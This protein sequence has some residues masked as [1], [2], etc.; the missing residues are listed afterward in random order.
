VK[1]RLLLVVLLT[2]TLLLVTPAVA[3][4]ITFASDLFSEG[5]NFGANQCVAPVGAWATLPAG[6]CWVS[7][8]NTGQGG[9]SP[10]NT[11]IN[12]VPTAV[13]TETVVLPYGDNSGYFQGWADDTMSVYIVNALHPGG[14]LL[15]AANNVW[16][17]HCVGQPIG[18]VDGMDWVGALDN[19]ILAQG[20]NTFLMPTYQLW[21]DGF[22]VAY[23][24]EVNSVPEPLS[25]FMIGGGLLALGFCGRR[26]TTA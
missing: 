21:G 3:T 20:V 24:G 18:C 2:S 26:K 5:N 9:W 16:S 22:A 8:S 7:F 12:G 23:R 11:T 17:S 15:H 19:T 13:F 25:A 10:P 1:L 6:T 4:T 14:L